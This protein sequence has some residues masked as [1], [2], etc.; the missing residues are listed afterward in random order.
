MCT[1]P[2]LNEILN[3]VDKE[4]SIISCRLSNNDKLQQK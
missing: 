1:K 4:Q 3:F 2:S